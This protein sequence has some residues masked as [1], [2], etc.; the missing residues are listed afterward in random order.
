[1]QRCYSMWRRV[2]QTIP[3]TL[4]GRQ[5]GTRFQIYRQADCATF[6]KR[7]ADEITKLGIDLLVAC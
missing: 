4:R 5:K 7:E 6:G 3:S 1:M 2:I